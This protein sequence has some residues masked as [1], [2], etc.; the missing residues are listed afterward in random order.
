MKIETKTVLTNTIPSGSYRGFGYLE[1]SALLASF[2]TK[3]ME[4]VNVDPVE[5]Y[6]KN[7]LKPGD[8]FPHTYMGTG[9]EVCVGPDISGA[10]AKGAEYCFH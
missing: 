3:A 8:R 5:Y 2:L 10:I 1:N 4:Q 7:C 6:K 9:F